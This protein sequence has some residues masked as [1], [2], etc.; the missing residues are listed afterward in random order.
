MSHVVM[1]SL[2][3]KL[4]TFERCG[5]EIEYENR[6]FY[7]LSLAGVCK[8]LLILRKMWEPKLFADSLFSIYKFNH[9]RLCSHEV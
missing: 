9:S 3:I 1:S 8:K 6:H 7:Q 2:L 5:P 4:F